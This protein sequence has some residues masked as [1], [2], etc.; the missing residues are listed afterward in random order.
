MNVKNKISEVCLIYNFAQHYRQA[1]FSKLD[2]TLLCDFYFGNK[3]GDVK[4]MD[5]S[6]LSGNV[7]E[8]ENVILFKPPFYWQKGVLKTI[9][10]PYKFYIVLGEYY[11]LSTWLLLIFALFSRKKVFLWTHGWYGNEGVVKTVVKKLFYGLSDKLLLYGN[12]AKQLMVSKGFREENMIVIYNSLDYEAQLKIRGNLKA[13]NLFFQR[14]GNNDPTLIF[15]GRLTKVKKLYQ[16]I[17]AHSILFNRGVK[18][19]LLLVGDGEARHDLET[20]LDKELVERIWF[21]G[22]SYNEHENA[23]L[24]YNADLCISPG[25]VGLTA[26]HSLMYGTPVITHSDLT[27][28]MPE[29]EAIKDGISGRFFEKDNVKE[30]SVVIEDWLQSKRDRDLVRS[31]CFK[32]IDEFYNPNYQ[33]QTI[34]RLIDEY[35]D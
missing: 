31:D 2:Q 4:K 1:I 29:A 8:V 32:I 28:Q 30:L 16:L 20:S 6:I 14:F 27:M 33:A 23:E 5:Y 35:N 22:A 11:C 24:L 25:N 18:T 12:Y 10:K 15:I 34:L 3:M 19:N 21:Y 9:F 17:E 7:T 13:E 26:I